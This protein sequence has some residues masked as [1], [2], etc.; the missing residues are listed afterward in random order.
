M[1]GDEDGEEGEEGDEGDD[2]DDGDE[3]DD[4]NDNDDDDDNDDDNDERENAAFTLPDASPFTNTQL[5]SSTAPRPRNTASTSSYVMRIGRCSRVHRTA[6]SAID[7]SSAKRMITVSARGFGV[8]TSSLVPASA[9]GANRP[10]GR[11]SA[12]CVVLSEQ[13]VATL[14]GYSGYTASQP[15]DTPT[16]VRIIIRYRPQ[17][18][19]EVQL[20]AQRDK[21]GGVRHVHRHRVGRQHADAVVHLRGLLSIR[22]HCYGDAV[23]RHRQRVEVASHLRVVVHTVPSLLATA[24]GGEE[25]GEEV[26][27]S[28]FAG[29]RKGCVAALTVDE[30]LRRVV[31]LQEA[32]RA[33]EICG[34][35]EKN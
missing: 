22:H 8:A 14:Q 33:E 31:G 16:L 7:P 26:L 3:G 2:G 23:D 30:E 19:V 27:R 32:Q 29:G 11:T 10:S 5:Q 15:P 21:R 34:L 25:A 13:A 28:G 24:G 35:R 6:Q 20:A 17:R 9:C 12:N 1:E 18:R 4:D